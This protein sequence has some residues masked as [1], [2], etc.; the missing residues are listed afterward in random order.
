MSSS[1]F[2]VCNLAAWPGD[3]EWAAVGAEMVDS[4]G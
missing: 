3:P 4:I 1:L 2:P